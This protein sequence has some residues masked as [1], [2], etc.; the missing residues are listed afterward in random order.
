LF[1]KI[2]NIVLSL[3]DGTFLK[4]KDRQK[5]AETIYTI[6]KEHLKNVEKNEILVLGTPRG[7]IEYK[8][9]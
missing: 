3:T 6:I 4:F 8:Q 1:F 2:S 7:G 5:A 9:N